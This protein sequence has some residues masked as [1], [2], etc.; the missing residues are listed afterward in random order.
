[1]RAY[2]RLLGYGPVARPFIFAAVAR[3]T[4]A[5]IPLGVLILVE[6][7]RQA[8]AIAGLVSGAYAVG[9]AVGTP[10]WGRLM[11]RFGQVTVLLPTTLASAALLVA[12]DDGDHR[13]GGGPGPGRARRRGRA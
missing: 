4:L 13:W 9:C 6:H 12:L 1:M 10:A 7:E 2:L 8:Y 11:D 3:L 5:M